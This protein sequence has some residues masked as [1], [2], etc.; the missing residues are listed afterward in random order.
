MLVTKAQSNR[1]EWLAYMTYVGAKDGTFAF[2]VPDK[3]YVACSNV[4][5]FNP[6]NAIITQILDSK[7]ASKSTLPRFTLSHM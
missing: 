1:M 4:Q 3:I 2:S 7:K 6:H 5:R